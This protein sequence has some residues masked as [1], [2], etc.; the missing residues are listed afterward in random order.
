MFQYIDIFVL[1]KKKHFKTGTALH[2]NAI[3][4]FLV[5]DKIVIVFAAKQIIKFVLISTSISVMNMR[6]S[7]AFAKTFFVS[8]YIKWY[9]IRWHCFAEAKTPIATVLGSPGSLSLKRMF[10]QTPPK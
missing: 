5:L 1:L 10:T 7:D 4:Q 6:I 3:L 2:T 9:I 8:V